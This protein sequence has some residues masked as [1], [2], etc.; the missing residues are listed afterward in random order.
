MPEQSR[1]RVPATC[2]GDRI[3]A[4]PAE[5]VVAGQPLFSC[6]EP[7]LDAQVAQAEALVREQEARLALAATAERVQLQMVR[8]ELAHQKQRLAD[9]AAR[10]GDLVVRSPHAGRFDMEALDD[11]S[12]RYLPRG[13]QVAYVLDPSRYT[14][15]AVVPQG[16]VDLVRQRAGKV[17]IR[18]A[19]RLWDV[20]QA[21]IVREVPGASAELPSMALALQGGGQIGLDPEA[22]ADNRAPKALEPLFQFE[23]Q[24]TG[25]AQPRYLGGRVHVRISH[26][27]APLGEQWYR[28]LRQQFMK[29]FAV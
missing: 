5:A 12:G 20:L 16:R 18:S 3:L 1:I 27:P 4:R 11:F 14:L 28:S 23:M 10:R 25:P 6:T 21:Q 15:L 26:N 13:E 24:F 22:S 19:E 9:L 8:S 7:E 29:R 17:E 2:F